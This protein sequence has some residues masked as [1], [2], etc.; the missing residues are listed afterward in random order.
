MSYT[1]K[2]ILRA[3]KKL[4]YEIREGRKHLLVFDP[5]TGRRVTTVPRG[6]IPKGDL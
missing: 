2:Q 5:V 3:A 1:S 6:Y 4:G